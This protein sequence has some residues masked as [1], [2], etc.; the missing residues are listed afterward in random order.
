FMQADTSTTRL[1]GG[2]G[3]GLA[4]SKRLVELMHGDIGVESELGKGSLFWFVLELGSAGVPEEHAQAER[5]RGLRF[6]VVDDNNTNR[7]FLQELI[8]SW[9]GVVEEAADAEQAL[10]VLRRAAA[11]GVR[12][13]IILL[14]MHMPKID[15]AELARRIS[16]DDRIAAPMVLLTSIVDQTREELV[17]AGIRAWLSKPLR[18]SNLLETLVQVLR[19]SAPNT[20]LAQSALGTVTEA[21][22]SNSRIKKPIRVLIAEDN[23]ANQEVLLG[24]S[25]H[26]GFEST[27]VGNGR[28]AFDALTNEHGYDVVLMDCQMPEMDGYT[29]TRA[30]REREAHE[31]RVRVPIIA[32]TAHAMQG[33]R[34]KVLSAGMDDYMTKPVDMEAL[35][36]K[37]ERWAR[38]IPPDPSSGEH[39][40][41][42]GA[43]PASMHLR[44]PAKDAAPSP[45]G[46]TPA[47]PA[48][49]GSPAT[50][51]N[52]S[53]HPLALD[54]SV[55]AQLKALQSPRRPRFF[56]DLV[57]K[58]AADAARHVDRMALAV[59]EESPEELKE[60]AHALKGS[61]R[62]IGAQ[63][64]AEVCDELESRGKAGSVE[65][66]SLLEDLKRELELALPALRNECNTSLS[67]Q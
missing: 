57:G 65:I 4:I 47:A 34:E 19:D 51:G 43:G 40:S 61:S 8:G 29:A 20:S 17:A 62:T 16:R 28:A 37:L 42:E 32:V 12:F 22:S 41:A 38:S 50:K 5:L 35:R 11:G 56:T 59:A 23:E 45:T 52:G 3:L 53:V 60:S 36:R 6:L 63:R 10:T 64:V 46:G 33:E 58:Y 9:G 27:I 67:P 24:I 31:G 55:V 54:A 21:S 18:Q 15:G 30:I 14:D 25:E 13:D 2:T 7:D 49:N 39:A 48:G 44:M 26:L 1:Y 66:G